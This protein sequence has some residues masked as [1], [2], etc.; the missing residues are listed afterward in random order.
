M[1]LTN[2]RLIP[3]IILT[4]AGLAPSSTMMSY[5]PTIVNSFGFERLKSNALVSIGAWMLL[6]TNISWGVLA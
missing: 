6:I 2:W 3:H 4:V 1:Q 5:A